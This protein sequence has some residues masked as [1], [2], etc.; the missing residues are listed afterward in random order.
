[1]APAIVQ[2]FA[3]HQTQKSSAFN[4]DQ[5]KMMFQFLLNTCRAWHE[6]GPFVE[7]FKKKFNMK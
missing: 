1:M 3:A 5:A 7:I 2:G 6:D 4:A